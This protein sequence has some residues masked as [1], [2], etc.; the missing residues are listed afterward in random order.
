MGSFYS[1]CLVSNMILTNQKTSV[2]LLVPNISENDDKSMIIA[3]NGCQEYY[4][5]FG[6]PINGEYYDY[7]H[8][9]NIIEDDNTRMLEEFFNMSISHIIERVGTR[10]DLPKDVK[11]SDLFKELSITYIR[12]EVLE[13]LQSGWDKMDLNNPKKYSFESHLSTLLKNIFSE[14]STKDEIEELSSKHPLTDEEK[15]RLRQL[16]FSDSSSYKYIKANSKFNMFDQLEIGE[17]FKESIIKQFLFLRK[18]YNTHGIFLRP[19]VYGSQYD[20]F[21]EI[22]ELNELV[23]D[24]LI[25]DIES[26]S[27]DYEDYDECSDEFKKIESILKR[28]NRGKFLNKLGI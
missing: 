19:V 9:D 21:V 6:F 17:N 27:K 2:I 28:Y 11:N 22:F 14:K 25:K 8:I 15:I 7:G 16:L 18:L 24:L 26:I 20:N 13:H 10:H 1:R 3:D 4:S 12:T 23:N 5:P